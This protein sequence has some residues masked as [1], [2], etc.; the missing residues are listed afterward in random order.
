MLGIWAT[1]ASGLLL[2]LIMSLVDSIDQPLAG[3]SF[4]GFWGFLFTEG[5]N[6]F[7][8]GLCW[9]F[10]ARWL[11]PRF[12]LRIILAISLASVVPIAALSLLYDRYLGAESYH[13][14][15]SAALA[16]HLAWMNLFYGMLYMAAFV[17][18]RKAARSRHT[19]SALRLA[20]DRSLAELD[21]K[22]LNSV[23]GQ[24]QPDLIL[25][26]LERLR[27]VYRHA[28]ER[29]DDL[30]DLLVAFLRAAVRG[31]TVRETNVASEL[32][33]AAYY[34]QLQSQLGGKVHQL[35]IAADQPMPEIPFPP[36]LLMPVIEH[37]LAAGGRTRLEAGWQGP[38]FQAVLS[39]DHA[40]PGP[41]PAPLRQRAET[42]PGPPDTSIESRISETADS[43]AWR[44]R[45]QRRGE[46]SSL[47][48]QT[49]GAFP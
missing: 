31:L 10:L 43:F 22:R 42:I 24:L 37:L 9:A 26:A 49:A 35:S 11:E 28:P 16:S 7:L 30:L 13:W 3:G 14:L 39:A 34:L 38:V 27:S 23:R 33:L 48:P 6:N 1:L 32:E 15:G 4:A 25:K 44:L 19:M 41:I 46:T 2:G 45:I 17:S 29:A 18:I 20:R 47:Q 8:H 21:A 12:D 5:H 40:A 36:G